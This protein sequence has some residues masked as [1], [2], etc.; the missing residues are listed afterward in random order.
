VNY[1]DEWLAPP[2]L[3]FFKSS[4]FPKRKRPGC[5]LCGGESW[6][7]DGVESIC[8]DC[9]WRIRPRRDL[10]PAWWDK[11]DRTDRAEAH[12]AWV[13]KAR[14]LQGPRRAPRRRD[15]LPPTYDDDAQDDQHE[16]PDARIADA[17][18]SLLWFP[19]VPPPAPLTEGS[20]NPPQ[21]WD[22]AGATGRIRQRL[23]GR[24]PALDP[25]VMTQAE[26]AGA[27]RDSVEKARTQ[28]EEE[29][30]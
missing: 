13:E 22:A 2:D 4:T 3:D 6:S 8:Y 27:L 12:R 19:P 21:W 29:Q 30:P 23:G 7:T 10:W 17:V 9:Y 24:E 1:R 5:A 18:A 15:E 25:S 28:K 14:D 16:R 11:N 26:L 20:G